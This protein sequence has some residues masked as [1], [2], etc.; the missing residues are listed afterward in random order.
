M[1]EERKKAVTVMVTT[2]GQNGIS[3]IIDINRYSSL[4]KLLRV[5]AYVKRFIENLKQKAAKKEMNF[6][7][8]RG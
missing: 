6:E 4:R 1:K 2:E 3:R 8:R 5:T 7:R